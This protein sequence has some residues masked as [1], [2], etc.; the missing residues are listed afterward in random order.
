MTCDEKL[1]YMRIMGEIDSEE[2]DDVLVAYLDLAKQKLINHIYP[3]EKNVVEIE[4]KYEMKQV[5]LAIILY[6]K[7]GANGEEHHNENGVNRK[8]QTEA[9]FLASIPRKVGIP[10]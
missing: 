5:E 10:L 1:N 4:P 9:S 7:R 3:F 8:Y 2:Q 6:D